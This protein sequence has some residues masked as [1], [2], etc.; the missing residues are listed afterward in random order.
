MRKQKVV[1]INKE[2]CTGCGLCVSMCPQKILFIDKETG[3]CS[4]TDDNKCDRL[5]GCERV[6]PADAIKIK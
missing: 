2:N 4:V 6:C 3:K 1:D 5:G